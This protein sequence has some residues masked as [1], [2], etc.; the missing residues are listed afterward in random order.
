MI[1]KVVWV[2]KMFKFYKIFL[3][4][5]KEICVIKNTFKSSN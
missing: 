2:N 3:T 5:K 4:D 1:F